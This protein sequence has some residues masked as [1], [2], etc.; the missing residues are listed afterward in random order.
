MPPGSLLISLR[1][2]AS[3]TR[4]EIF[5]V[6]AT[7]CSDNPRFS[8]ARLRSGPN[9]V[10]AS[11]FMSI[12]PIA[13]CQLRDGPCYIIRTRLRTLVRHLFTKVALTGKKGNQF[14]QAGPEIDDTKTR[15]RPLHESARDHHPENGPAVDKI[16][17]LQKA[18]PWHDQQQQAHLHEVGDRHQAPQQVHAVPPDRG[19][20]HCER[21][22]DNSAIR[23]STSRK[24]A[25][26]DCSSMHTA[27]ARAPCPSATT[28]TA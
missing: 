21:R 13:T 11:S 10:R 24:P 16:V 9:S 2:R 27:R 4:A 23:C 18:G 3:S 22:S 15:N 8:R 6:A 5:V 26:E 12:A 25:A 14:D 19:R 20:A 7:C 1:S 17:A 28:G